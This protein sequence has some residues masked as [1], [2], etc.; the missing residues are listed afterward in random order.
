MIAKPPLVDADLCT[1]CQA[2]LAGCPNQA[3]ADCL[4]NG[5]WELWYRPERCLFCGRCAKIC[6]EGALSYSQEGLPPAVR[7]QAERL[8]RLPALT[9]PECGRVFLS[10]AGAPNCTPAAQSIRPAGAERPAGLVPRVCRASA[11][12]EA[13]MRTTRGEVKS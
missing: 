3:L 9:C 8:T 4:E 11:S 1:G 6:P 10:E 5:F 13:L 2:C 12:A 7:I